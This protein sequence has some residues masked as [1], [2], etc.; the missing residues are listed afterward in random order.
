[1]VA[2]TGLF[3]GGRHLFPQRLINFLQSRNEIV[4]EMVWLIAFFVQ[5]ELGKW[6]YT[7]V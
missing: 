5:G 2:Q 7:L 6:P 1:M 3:A 4:E